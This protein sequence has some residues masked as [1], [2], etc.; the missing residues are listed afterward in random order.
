M[1]RE[2]EGFPGHCQLRKIHV[3]WPS[4]N[5]LKGHQTRRKAWFF[6]ACNL[7]EG[8]L[9]LE[10]D[11]KLLYTWHARTFQ[12][13][14]IY[15]WLNS[16]QK[17]QDKLPIWHVPAVPSAEIAYFLY[18]VQRKCLEGFHTLLLSYKGEVNLDRNQ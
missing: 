1:M 13:L 5:D 18:T 16:D 11:Y 12:V 15:S 9:T 8:I 7:Y 4:E 6:K 17:E 14:S 10:W 3:G 2:L